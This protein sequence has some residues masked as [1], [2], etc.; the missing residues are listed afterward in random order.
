L[1]EKFTLNTKFCLQYPNILLT[2][3]KN[4]RTWF[5]TNHSSRVPWVLV[6]TA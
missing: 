4:K 1:Y 3:V 2:P 6:V 5:T